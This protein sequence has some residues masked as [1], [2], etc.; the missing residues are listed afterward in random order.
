MGMYGQIDFCDD[1]L[2]GVGGVVS[3]S[4]FGICLTKVMTSMVMVAVAHYNIE[5]K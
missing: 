4:V 2:N 5:G 3:L 1:G